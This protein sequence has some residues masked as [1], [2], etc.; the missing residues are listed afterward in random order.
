MTSALDGVGGQSHVTNA[1]LLPGKG[2]PVPTVRRLCGAVVSVL[3]TGP[4]GRGLE[5]NQ[6]DEILRTIII[7]STH[8]FRMGNKAG[9][10]LVVRLYGM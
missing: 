9:R 7:R 3:A 5:P 8:S 6:G 4:K 2:P 10:S 1:P